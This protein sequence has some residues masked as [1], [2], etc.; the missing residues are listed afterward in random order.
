[1]GS[2]AQLPYHMT[3]PYKISAGNNLASINK[4]NNDKK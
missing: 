2:H 3:K 4:N 1:M